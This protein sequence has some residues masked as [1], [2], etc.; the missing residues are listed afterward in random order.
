ML[1]DREAC[2]GCG[3]CVPYCPMEAILWYK[4]RDK[5]KGVKP[6]SEIDR[7]KCVECS[8]CFRAKVCPPDAIHEEKLEWPRILRRAFSDPLYVHG[9]T[10]IPGRGTEEMKTNDVTGRYLNGYI[11]VGMEFGRPG[12]GT[13]LRDT[14][15]AIKRLVKMGV[16]LEPLNP[17]TQLIENK[18]TGELRREVLNEKVLSAIVEFTVPIEKAQEVFR[19]VKEIAREVDTVFSL[20]L[21]C[22]VAPDGNI[23][24]RKEVEKTGFIRSI[25]GKINVGLGRPFYKA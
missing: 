24:I 23:P 8:V 18:D 7:E 21:I 15:K 4:K 14:E 3:K 1:I 5:K 2:T 11:G 12:T 17:L 22:K 10:D 16:S 13:Y 19:A 6:Y 9:G 25:N 20:D